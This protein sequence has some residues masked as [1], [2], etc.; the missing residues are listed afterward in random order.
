M[1]TRKK[2]VLILFLLFLILLTGALGFTLHFI[3][4]QDSIRNSA[5]ASVFADSVAKLIRV[6][7]SG[8]L[9]RFSGVV[10]PQKTWNL[11]HSSE[12]KILELFVK[13]GDM[14][15]AGDKLLTYDTTSDQ[16]ELTAGGIEEDRL[17]ENIKNLTSQIAS[18]QNEKKKAPADQ[19]LDYSQRILSAQNELKKAQYDLQKQQAKNENLKKSIANATVTSELSGLV[20]TVRNPENASSSGDDSDTLITVVAVG[21]FRIKGTLNEQ[22]RQSLSEGDPVL[23]YSRTDNAQVWKGTLSEIDVE[24]PTTRQNPSDGAQKGINASQS[25]NYPFFVE[26]S[27]VQGL[28]AG[29]HVYV[30]PDCGQADVR[31]GI[32]LDSYYLVQEDGQAY[33]WAADSRDL[34][35]KRAVTLGTFD[36]KLQKYEI[37][38]GLTEE[39]Y[40]AFPNGRIQEGAPVEKNI[41]LMA[42]YPTD[43][44]GTAA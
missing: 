34:I 37:L 38:E 43:T 12:K 17:N 16:E 4:N 35:E 21:Q 18:F 40:I 2:K 3:R 20:R 11:M 25:S 44:A 42:V 5:K 19:Q 23:I 41:D 8:T 32:W 24:N 1:K 13:E 10:E 7:N 14:V 28:M 36:E 30:E 9:P 22:N 6:G 27:D 31:S 26:V 29:Q 39:D 33:V 15:K